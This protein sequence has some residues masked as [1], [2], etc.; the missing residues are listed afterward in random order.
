MSF[1]STVTALSPY[2][3]YRCNESSGTTLTDS[4]GNTRN[5]T[6]SGT[7][8]QSQTGF[9]NDGNH[10][11]LSTANTFFNLTSAA[12]QPGNGT[13]VPFTLGFVYKPGTL[14]TSYVASAQNGDSSHFWQLIH[15]I[16]SPNTVT[17]VLNTVTIG[18]CQDNA[19]PLSSNGGV[20]MLWLTYDGSGAW[21]LY[22]NGSSTPVISA[23]GK[24]ITQNSTAFSLIVD[25]STGNTNLSLVGNFQDIM[26]FNSVLSAANRASVFSSTGIVPALVP[27]VTSGTNLPTGA[28]ISW[29]TN[30]TGGVAPITYQLYRQSIPSS[31]IAGAT[32]VYT[33]TT[34][35]YIDDPGDY[36]LYYYVVKATDSTGQTIQNLLYPG[37]KQKSY[38]LF[39]IGDSRTMGINADYTA[40]G[41]PITQLAYQLDAKLGNANWNIINR[42]ASGAMASHWIPG[43]TTYGGTQA[44]GGTRYPFTTGQSLFDTAMSAFDTALA[45]YPA[46]TKVYFNIMLGANES[47][48]TQR[49][50][51]ATYIANMQTVIN[52]IKAH[53]FPGFAGIIIHCSYYSVP[54]WDPAHVSYDELSNYLMIQYN[55]AISQLV[56]N[57]TV[58]MGDQNAYKFFAA[59]AQGSLGL[60][61]IDGVH[62][63]DM[64]YSAQATLWAQAYLQLFGAAVA[65]GTTY[66]KTVPLSQVSSG[67]ATVGIPWVIPAAGIPGSNGTIQ[68]G[69]TTVSISGSGVSEI[70]NLVDQMLRDGRAVIS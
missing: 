50:P 33:G 52:G 17:L 5:G 49:V 12:S 2:A 14:T 11:V 67:N 41:D 64:G 36:G 45:G 27:G 23:T 55:A 28:S 60:L 48:I 54:Y 8:T 25:A 65:A 43:N 58:F 47:T 69:S 40:G 68:S 39:A 13:N 18:T 19:I 35:S 61:N 30:G 1:A 44:N 59:F 10:S 51:V 24:P 34:P 16:G 26:L 62:P 15:N 6:Y 66:P 3:W 57:T 7:Y 9:T 22:V 38:A 21:G 46:G 42:G 4:S 37:Q 63:T 31:S 56:D 32:L 29:T 20:V 53:N 70:S